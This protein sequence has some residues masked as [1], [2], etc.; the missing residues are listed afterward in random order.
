MSEADNEYIL[1]RFD[2][3]MEFRVALG[4]E[5]DRGCALMAGE[6]LS[7]QLGE[8]LRASFVNDAKASA[9]VLDDPNGPLGTF[10]SRIEFAYLLG[11][12]G[13]AAWRELHLI[14]KV[15]NEFAHDYRPL[16][17]DDM[18]IANRCRELRAHALVPLERPRAQF[19]QTVM[20]LAAVIHGRGRAAKHAKAGTDILTTLAPE[21]LH[22]MGEEVEKLAE[23]LVK[24]LGLT[25]KGEEG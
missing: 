7:D 5:T 2:D 14:R 6:Y 11:L 22:A 9:S 23:A 21:E 4:R 3:V 8:L 18:S 15:R 24:A 1:K 19:T 17:F 25:E 10:S 13:P 20:G 12:V 16:T